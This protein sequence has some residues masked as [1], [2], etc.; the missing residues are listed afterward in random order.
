MQSLYRPTRLKLSYNP[1]GELVHLI[2][3]KFK[4]YKRLKRLNNQTHH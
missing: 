3:R 2:T 1:T 4:A